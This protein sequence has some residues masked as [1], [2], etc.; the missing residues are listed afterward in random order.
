MLKSNTVFLDVVAQSLYIDLGSRLSSIAQKDIA[1]LR[2]R[3]DQEGF[4]FLQIACTQ[5]CVAL[6]SGLETGRFQLK[7][8]FQKKGS[9][10]LPCFLN[11]WFQLVFTQDGTLRQDADVDAIEC[12]YQFLAFWKKCETGEDFDEAKATSKWLAIERSVEVLDARWLNRARSFLAESGLDNED[13][14]ALEGKYRPTH[15]AGSV[16]QKGFTPRWKYSFAAATTG[17]DTEVQLDT[18][19]DMMSDFGVDTSSIG[20]NDGKQKFP[21]REIA[22]RIQEHRTR[23][24]MEQGPLGPPSWLCELFGYRGV[25]MPRPESATVP[26]RLCFVP[27]D[28]GGPRTIICEDLWLM[29]FQQALRLMLQDYLE[30]NAPFKGFINFTS[31]DVMRRLALASSVTQEWATMDLKD[32]SDRVLELAVNATFPPRLASALMILRNPEV[33][34]PGSIDG[35]EDRFL[36]SLRKYAGMGSALCFPVEALFFY[37]LLK[38]NGIE[39][40]VYGDDIIIRKEMLALAKSILTD[41]GL[42][43]NERKTFAHG[44]FRESCGCDA[45]D[46]RDITPVRLRKVPWGPKDPTHMIPPAKMAGFCDTVNQL[47]RKGLTLTAR[48][49]E[50]YIPNSIARERTESGLHIAHPPVFEGE[51]WDIALQKRIT[52]TWVPAASRERLSMPKLGVDL[53]AFVDFLDSEEAAYNAWSDQ[54]SGVNPDENNRFNLGHLEGARSLITLSRREDEPKYRRKYVACA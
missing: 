54:N 40:Y 37:A 35:H 15:S 25:F 20:E 13:W 43:V 11:G 9:S 41:S 17:S 6:L 29:Y 48:A 53:D 31:Q 49:I 39:A 52:R 42:A 18:L 22:R 24:E 51:T 16:A 3:Y 23:Y 26:A 32:A 27:K 38:G 30:S 44:K 8:F 2:R 7:G 19:V 46:G 47:M 5:L 45:Y 28:V 14:F 10:A 4:S 50:R 33:S 34:L 1:T 36:H 12:L 21:A